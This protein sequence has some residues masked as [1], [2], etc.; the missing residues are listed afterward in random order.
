MFSTLEKIISH[1]AIYTQI[2]V[3][4]PTYRVIVAG[5][6]CSGL[7]TAL[8]GPEAGQR[9]DFALGKHQGHLRVAAGDPRRALADGG[10]PEGRYGNVERIVVGG[11]RDHEICECGTLPSA[12][13]AVVWSH[14]YK[15]P[16]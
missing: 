8:G 1:Q 16:I 6:V 12:F 4:G 14:L 11:I 3:L 10:R 15:L 2:A 5:A 13:C 9:A 7:Q